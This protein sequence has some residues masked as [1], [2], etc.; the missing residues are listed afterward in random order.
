MTA[1]PALE[2]DARLQRSS[3][4]PAT[5]PAM[6]SRW[7]ASVLPAGS[8]PSV[9]VDSSVDANGMSSETIVFTAGW[10]QD[11]HDVS[12]RFVARVAPAPHDV[13]VFP[14]Y[15]LGNQFQVLQLVARHST[16]PVPAVHWYEPDP[17]ALGTP[18]FVMDHIDGRIPSDVMPYT[19]GGNWLYDATPQQ[20]RELQDATVEVIAG[21]HS[22]DEPTTV[23]AFLADEAA[24]EDVLA[25]HFRRTK[26]WYD[27]AVADLGRSQ[28]VDRCVDW[29]EKHWEQSVS[30]SDPVL[31]WGDA[32]IGNVLYR[33]FRPVAV[34]DWEM[35]CLGPRQLDIA[36]LIFSHLFFE[37][38]AAL[39]G[40]PGMPHFLKEDDVRATYQALT[41]VDLADLRWF[42]VYA[43]VLWSCALMRVGA[44]R[45]HFGE[46][47]KPDVVEALFYHAPILEKL[48]STPGGNP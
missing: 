21:V 46:M 32:R 39:A 2:D 48:I 47:E 27:F 12:K 17:A 43:G 11:G 29:L 5:L 19:L 25:D 20:Q 31:L 40:M 7:L 42:C 41:G 26:A 14:Q 4:D 1:K 22:I 8:E 36:W 13:P 34:L 44:R 9:S 15:R 37:E 6:L 23:F 28:L 33:G 45:I 16:V 24:G 35:T 30:T 10:R 3:R 18:F 38:I